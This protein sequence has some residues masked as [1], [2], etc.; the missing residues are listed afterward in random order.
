MDPPRVSP[1]LKDNGRGQSSKRVVRQQTRKLSTKKENTIVKPKRRCTK[2]TSSSYV[3]VTDALGR[4]SYGLAEFLEKRAEERRQE[5]EADQT[6]W[7]G[8][9]AKDREFLRKLL[10]NK[11]SAAVLEVCN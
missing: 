3:A 8:E 6:F 4:Q 2:K 7:A 11:L 9:T 5:R 1:R 10:S